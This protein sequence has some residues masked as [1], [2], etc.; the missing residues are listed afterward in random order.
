MRP[1]WP[2]FCQYS[3]LQLNCLESGTRSLSSSSLHNKRLLPAIFLHNGYE[4]YSSGTISMIR[5]TGLLQNCGDTT[6]PLACSVY[7]IHNMLELSLGPTP[8]LE[9][10]PLFP[11]SDYL[12]S[13][14]VATLH[15]WRLAAAWQQAFLWWQED[16]LGMGFTVLKG[17]NFRKIQGFPLEMFS[18]LH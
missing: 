12:I 17:Y 9:E 2:V 11:S 14:F 15:I 8:S 13:T 6:Q 5:P 7:T 4:L 16:S 3:R 18:P 10:H 1:S